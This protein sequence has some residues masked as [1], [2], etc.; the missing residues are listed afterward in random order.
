VADWKLKMKVNKKVN[1]KR[2]SIY[3]DA[4]VAE[5]INQEAVRLGAKSSNSLISDILRDGLKRLGV[6]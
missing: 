3:I 4:D 6:L 2:M 5:K 1:K